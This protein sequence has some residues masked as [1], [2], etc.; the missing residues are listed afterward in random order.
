MLF[1]FPHRF[2]SFDRFTQFYRSVG[3]D[4]WIVSNRCMEICFLESDLAAV[5][6]EREYQ[7]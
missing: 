6:P 3:S 5:L 4:L 2:G 7:C 1:F